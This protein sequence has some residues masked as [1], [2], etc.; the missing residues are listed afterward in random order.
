MAPGGLFG[1]AAVA[2]VVSLAVHVALNCP[3]QPV[4][5]P[6]PPPARHTPNN[7]L[8]VSC[9]SAT[10]SSYVPPPV[11]IGIL[12]RLHRGSRSLGKGG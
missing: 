7:L 12:D 10:S 9:S 11:L 3:I 5:S 8:Q 1:T 4:P 6:P 2:V